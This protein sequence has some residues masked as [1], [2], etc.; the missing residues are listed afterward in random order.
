MD[1]H[2]AVVVAASTGKATINVNGTTLHS[3]FVLPV[4]GG[5][6]F[7]QPVWDKKKKF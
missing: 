2:P 7:T 4:R 1:E 6:T 3:E 5:V